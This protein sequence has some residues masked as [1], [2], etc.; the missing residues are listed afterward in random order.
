M[1]TRDALAKQ[2]LTSKQLD[3][4]IHDPANAYSI[5]TIAQQ[6]AALAEKIR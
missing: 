3:Q 4:D 6:I 2:G 1:A 5:R